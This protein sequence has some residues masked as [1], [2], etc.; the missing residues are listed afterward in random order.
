M[1]YMGYRSRNY[2]M[3]GPFS[4]YIDVFLLSDPSDLVASG[5]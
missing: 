2:A 5:A 1:H 3:P 4:N